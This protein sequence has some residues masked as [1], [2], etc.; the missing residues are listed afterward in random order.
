[1]GSTRTTKSPMAIHEASP[2]L[3]PKAPS[4][5]INNPN[6]PPIGFGSN[7]PSREPR[8]NSSTSPEPLDFSVT[9]FK[10]EPAHNRS[11]SPRQ[12]DGRSKTLNK[13]EAEKASRENSR[14]H[15]PLSEQGS[16]LSLFGSDGAKRHSYIMDGSG[17]EKAHLPEG[18]RKMSA[19]DQNRWISAAGP[20]KVQTLK[21]PPMPKPTVGQLRRA[22]AEDPTRSKKPPMR[23]PLQRPDPPLLRPRSRGEEM[24]VSNLTVVKPLFEGEQAERGMLQLDGFLLLQVACAELPEE[25]ETADLSGRSIFRV[26]EADLPH[27]T[28]LRDINVSDNMIS[29]LMP[30]SGLPSLKYL[31]ASANGFSSLAVAPGML[32]SLQVLDLSFNNLSAAMAF[33]QL[34]DLPSLK[35][36]DLSGNSMPQLPSTIIGFTALEHLSLACN[37]LRGRSLLSLQRLPSLKKLHLQDNIISKLPEWDATEPFPALEEIDLTNNHI[38]HASAIVSLEELPSLCRVVLAGNPLSSKANLAAKRAVRAIDAEYRAAGL[39]ELTANPDKVLQAAV[40]PEPSAILLA[41]PSPADEL[42]VAATL[43]VSEEPSSQLSRIRVELNAPQLKP[44]SLSDTYTVAKIP[45]VIDE[46][47]KPLPDPNNPLAGMTGMVRDEDINHNAVMEAFGRLN[48]EIVGWGVHAEEVGYG[49]EPV[50]EG[51][52]EDVEGAGEDYADNTFLTGIAMEGLP[53]EEEVPEEQRGDAAQGTGSRDGSNAP[54]G[55]EEDPTVRLA[56]ALGLDPSLLSIN[57]GHLGGDC[58]AAIKALRFA[59]AHPLVDENEG[60]R[61]KPHHFK[62]TASVRAKQREK[63]LPL[64]TPPQALPALDYKVERIQTIE[65]ILS[66]MKARLEKVETNLVAEIGEESVELA[67]ATARLGS[68]ASTASYITGGVSAGSDQPSST[69]LA[70]LSPDTNKLRPSPLGNGS[71]LSTAGPPAQVPLVPPIAVAQNKAAAAS[72]LGYS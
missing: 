40:A 49:L 39:P 34:C 18:V 13:I 12:R 16:Q 24:A 19:R 25:V 62:S 60:L 71:K 58:T 30:L 48:S 42:S 37:G 61:P 51:L 38:R 4:I 63:L 53:E 15:T 21:P 35:K 32:S 57:S 56:I 20:K 43:P 33:D 36:L 72:T 29:S 55:E 5:R 52:E 27:F 50:H 8:N 1:M 59:L 70:P 6:P 7:I 67:L 26:E 17:E 44:P 54:A 22:Q 9:A 69:S 65:D 66:G 45:V 14:L 2:L 11:Q 64:D 41:L 47:A 23:A 3:E 46:T 68:A 10:I 31:Q 28:N